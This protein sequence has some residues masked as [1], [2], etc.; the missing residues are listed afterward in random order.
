MYSGGNSYITASTGFGAA[1]AWGIVPC[2]N[3]FIVSSDAFSK[4]VPNASMWFQGN[5]TQH[6]S[7]YSFASTLDRIQVGRETSSRKTAY[8]WQ[9]IWR[10]R[11]TFRVLEEDGIG[12]RLCSNKRYKNGEIPFEEYRVYLNPS[13][14][15][16][17]LVLAFA[18]MLLTL[19]PCPKTAF[20][21]IEEDPKR[22]KHDPDYTKLV[23][24][25]ECA[26]KA[27]ALVKLILR[28]PQL[29]Y[30]MAGASVLSNTVPVNNLVQV[31]GGPR[32]DFGIFSEP[33]IERTEE[34]R[35]V[36]ACKGIPLM[37]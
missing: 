37:A 34:I 14:E 25:F 35:D 9:R 17:D 2:A 21:Y 22:K 36:F 18:L 23:F 30:L 8:R 24:Y 6:K 10:G 1:K 28:Y 7:G 3:D 11:N 33:V 26:E 27:A 32:E 29:D 16:F 15:M 31:L 12:W 13:A 4:F 20:K 19:P 5:Y